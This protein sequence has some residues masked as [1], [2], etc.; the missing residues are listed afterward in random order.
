M[1]KNIGIELGW[2][3]LGGVSD[4]C[5]PAIKRAMPIC[6]DVSPPFDAPLGR[7]TSGNAY[8]WWR[9]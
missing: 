6:F 8:T 4:A 2:S 9:A 5:N 3:F 1:S 7:T